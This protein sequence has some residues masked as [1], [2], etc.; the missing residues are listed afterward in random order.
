MHLSNAL[1]TTSVIGKSLIAISYGASRVFHCFIQY[2]T[3]NR[4][5]Q[6]KITFT[7][8]VPYR[9]WVNMH[10]SADIE[11][12]KTIGLLIMSVDRIVIRY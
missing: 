4:G 12:E 5:P 7:V 3:I 1:Y 6:Y 9:I 11:H 8:E 10:C 2:D